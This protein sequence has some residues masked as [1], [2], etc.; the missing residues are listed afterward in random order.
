MK[1]YTLVEI[2][3]SITILSL[4]FVSGYAGFREF[5]R[6]QFVNSQARAV[7][8]DL[9]LIQSRAAS[10]EKP[11]DLDCNLPNRL[12][13]YIFE[14]VNDSGYKLSAR[15]SDKNVLVKE[16]FFPDGLTIQ[17]TIQPILF[18]VLSQGTNLGAG[19]TSTIT[20]TETVGGKVRAITVGAG[21]EIK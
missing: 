6:R 19:L 10:G 5:S 17:A 21:G 14:L 1:G 13:G 4:I 3:I 18:K 12:Q 16:E 15:C 20:I 7:V 8:G 9:R 2:L 11:D